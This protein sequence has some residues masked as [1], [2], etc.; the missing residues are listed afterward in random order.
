MLPC[1]S[2]VS[3]SPLVVPVIEETLALRTSPVETGRIRIRKVV[4]E[5]EEIVDP[6]LAHD[7]VIDE[8]VPLNRIVEG[9]APVC[10]EGDTL[11]IPLLEEVLVVGKRLL[12]KEEVRITNRRVDTHAPSG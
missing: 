5:C 4:H 2:G 1:S 3:E 8:P 7:E 9:P 6:P 10:S 12:L 11:V